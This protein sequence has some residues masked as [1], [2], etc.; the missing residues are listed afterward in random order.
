MANTSLNSLKVMA[1]NRRD[2]EPDI[3]ATYLHFLLEPGEHQ[4]GCL[5]LYSFLQQIQRTLRGEP[6]LTETLRKIREHL[7]SSSRGLPDKISIASKLDVEGVPL[8]LLITNDQYTLLIEIHSGNSQSSRLLEAYKNFI[9]LHPLKAGHRI[10]CVIIGRENLITNNWKK[11]LRQVDKLSFIRF[12]ETQDSLPS[13]QTS[14]LNVFQKYAYNTNDNINQGSG[15]KYP[16]GFS[17]LKDLSEF[18]SN[19]LQG[20][21]SQLLPEDLQGITYVNCFELGKQSGGYVYI[22]NGLSGLLRMRPEYIEM[23]KFA[24]S[25]DHLNA[26]GWLSVKRVNSYLK[27]FL[28]QSLNDT[29]A[30]ISRRTKKR[31]QRGKCRKF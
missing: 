27:W 21:G 6:F 26:P 8:D 18:I 24:F 4:L 9:R 23:N 15:L 31:Y 29:R 25:R 20:Y 17:V 1:F 14:I 19:D 5:Y 7:D 10:L 16:L 13:I 3:L 2:I 28:S 12:H 22:Q 30:I 11:A